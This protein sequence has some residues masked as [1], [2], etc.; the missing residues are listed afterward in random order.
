MVFQQILFAVTYAI[1]YAAFCAFKY[2]YSVPVQSYSNFLLDVQQRICPQ[3][4][5]QQFCRN[6]TY[7]VRMLAVSMFISTMGA[8]CYSAK[9][10]ASFYGNAEDSPDYANYSPRTENVERIFAEECLESEK[11][12]YPAKNASADDSAEKESTPN[13]SSVTSTFDKMNES[14][15]ISPSDEIGTATTVGSSQLARSEDGLGNEPIQA[16][17][18]SFIQGE[19]RKE[20]VS[21][22]SNGSNRDGDKISLDDLFA[23]EKSVIERGKDD[24][25]QESQTSSRQTRHSKGRPRGQTVERLI[26]ELKKKGLDEGSDDYKRNEKRREPHPKD[27]SDYYVGMKVTKQ[28]QPTEHDEKITGGTK[29]EEIKSSSHSSGNS[30]EKFVKNMNTK[31]EKTS[32]EDTTESEDYETN[33]ESNSSESDCPECQALQKEYDYTSES[34]SDKKPDI[35]LPIELLNM[36][37]PKA[38]KAFS[39][40]MELLQVQDG[41]HNEKVQRETFEKIIELVKQAEA[42]S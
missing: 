42:V 11:E 16:S 21:E 1:S 19:G 14:T 9:K 4:S 41:L 36:L 27:T 12:Q 5:Q 34:E 20:S 40:Q 24:G 18:Q 17:S 25:S 15:E 31:L 33:S 22:K 29:H 39:E 7:L 23:K 3:S 38:N 8:V 26:H 30:L 32:A 2:A 13:T 35:F 6:D 28:K 10:L 37:D